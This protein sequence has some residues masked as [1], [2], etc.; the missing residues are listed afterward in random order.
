MDELQDR[1]DELDNI[2]SVLRVLTNEI[3]DEG[4]KDILMDIMFKA[5]NEKE[6]IEP[7]LQ[8]MYDAEERQ[9]N[10]EYWDSQF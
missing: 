1:Y 8:A 2:E 7:R 4:Y 9:L 5:Q 3:E 10:K 6:E